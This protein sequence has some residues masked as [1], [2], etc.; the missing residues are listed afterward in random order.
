MRTGINI[1]APVA[2]CTSTSYFLPT[3]TIFTMS[4]YNPEY[5]NG[6]N[7]Y[8][9]EGFGSSHPGSV[10]HGDSSGS[11]APKYGHY[12]PRG[13]RRSGGGNH[14]HGYRSAPSQQYRDVMSPEEWYRK[15]LRDTLF[16]LG[17]RKEGSQDEFHPPSELF[18]LKEETERLGSKGG[19]DLA[20]IASS[21]KI[22]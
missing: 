19:E 20:M 4:E 10:R 12:G 9:S 15:R 22:M 7:L 1:V 16:R 14:S 3:L 5:L 18:R 21:I 11:G 6:Q 17:D 2:Q 8:G 13:P